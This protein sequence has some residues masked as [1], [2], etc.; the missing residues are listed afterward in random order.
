MKTILER[1]VFGDPARVTRT[2]R[3][4][5]P[6]AVKAGQYLSLRRDLLPRELTDELLKL[7]DDGPAL[8]WTEVKEILTADLGSAPELIFSY[9][10]RA[11]MA[12]GSLAQVHRARLPD[13]TEVAIKVKRPRIEDAIAGELKRLRRLAAFVARSRADLAINPRELIDEIAEWLKHE[14]D[15]VREL[16]N[17]RRLRRLAI[18]SNIQRIPLVYPSLS[19]QRIVTYEWLRG[20]PVSTVLSR[21]A[22]VPASV[23]ADLDGAQ[24]SSQAGEIDEQA[25]AANLMEACLTQIFG[26]QFFH[27]D[28]HPGNLLIL[29]GNVIGFVDFGFCDAL[30]DTVRKN[31]LRYL[32]AAYNDDASLMFKALIEILIAGEMADSEGFRRDFLNVWRK[33]EGRNNESDQPASDYLSSILNVARH[34]GYQVPTSILS[35]YRALLTAESVAAQLGLADGI[36]E[37]GRKFFTELQSQELYSQLFDRDQLRQ[38]FMSLLNLTRD[39]PKQVNQILSDIADGTL[40][41]KVEVSEDPRIAKSRRQRAKM[42]VCAILSAGV[43]VL[44]AMPN[45]PAVFGLGLQRVLG[46]VLLGLYVAVIYFSRQL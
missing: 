41:L 43:A 22:S 24:S 26:Y 29:E 25:I 2:L 20:I 34:N 19:S 30:D 15:F 35:I 45:P 6:I 1:V 4:M 17:A 40:S 7:T 46:L 8:A 32:T 37:I 44:M 28:L 9:I 33:L 23:G 21:Q 5:G 12:S 36:R 3:R 39:G 13:G 42:Q 16:D 18:G 38:V 27:A 10:D 14:V 31:Q 11:P